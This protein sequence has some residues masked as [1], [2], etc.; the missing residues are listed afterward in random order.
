MKKT[1]RI[2]TVCLLIATMVIGM[3]V[4]AFAYSTVAKGSAGK[5]VKTLQTMLNSVQNAGLVVD[6]MFGNATLSAVKTF[7]RNNGL[8]VD[9]IV[10]PK[11]WAALQ[12]KY[13]SGT[14]KAASTLSIGSGRYKPGSLSLGSSYSISGTVKSN[15]KLTAV[16]VGVYDANGNQTAQVRTAYP[17]STSYD[18]HKVDN[19]IKFGALAAGSY[20]FRVIAT[21]A[22]GTTKTLVKNSFT[23]K[24]PFSNNTSVS[25]FQKTALA[26]W[27]KPVKA[28]ILSVPG[29]G[30]AFGAY[31][32]SS[33]SHA[34]IDYYVSGG[35]GTPVYAM[36]S[37]KVIE[38]I[39]DFYYGTS[40]V[41]IQHADGSI[42]RYCEISTS[43]RMGSSV[44]RGQQIGKIKANSLDGGT[45][46]H[47]ELYL[48]TASGSLTNSSNTRYDYVS[49]QY[50]R[51]RDIIDPT[52]LLNLK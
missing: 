1:L 3:A 28:A 42:A 24:A 8:D 14:S 9:G 45:M 2:L 37:G 11:T 40:A 10:G 47:L 50:K 15:Y 4:P 30:R 41:A 31:R 29:T 23:V 49:G 22:S 20:T 26:N 48:G 21:D 13:K 32:T 34:G 25:A 6:G 44:S 5:D 12:A 39:S 16:T 17:G 33:R 35:S 52:F 43:L 38:Y 27:V 19:Y 7:Q 46:L 36:Q 18:I 51:R